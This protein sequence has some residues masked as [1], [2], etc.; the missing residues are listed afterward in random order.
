MSLGVL[1]AVVGSWYKH[2][3]WDS[4]QCALEGYQ[5]TCVQTQHGSQNSFFH[6]AAVAYAAGLVN[7][8]VE[9][10]SI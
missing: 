3:Q 1:W 9:N 4:T 7:V 6:A 8:P 2:L 5:C 10:K